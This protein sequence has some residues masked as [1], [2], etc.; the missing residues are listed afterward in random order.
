MNHFVFAS[1]CKDYN[2]LNLRLLANVEAPETT[3]SVQ[4]TEVP[5]YRAVPFQL[6]S[7]KLQHLLLGSSTHPA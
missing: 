2:Q 3:L 5:Q 7:S 6:I 4:G 1:A